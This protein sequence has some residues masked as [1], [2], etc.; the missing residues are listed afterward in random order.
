[1][2][3]AHCSTIIPRDSILAEHLWT[4]HLSYPLDKIISLLEE[5]DEDLFIVGS[6]L[7]AYLSEPSLSCDYYYISLL[8]SHIYYILF[9][10]P[11]VLSQPPCICSAFFS[12]FVCVCVFQSLTGILYYYYYIAQCVRS[13]SGTQSRDLDGQ[14]D[15]TPY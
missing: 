3:I 9:L 1:M 6:K 2:S 11:S 4:T 15:Y 14:R 13:S 12:S 7:K 5:G 8:I 10:S